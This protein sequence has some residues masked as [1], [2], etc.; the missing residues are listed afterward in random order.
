MPAAR[1][2]VEGVTA[3]YGPTEIVSDISFS[4]SAGERLAVFGRNGVG[5]T[6][7]LAAIMGL[8]TLRRGRIALNGEDL[9]GRRTSFRAQ[10]GLGYVPQTRGVF[11]SLTVEENLAAGLK[12]R[13]RS[14][15][16]EAYEMF[17]RLAER[18]T[19]LAQRLSGGE[20][21]MLALARTLLGEPTI[22]LLDEPLE[23]IAPVVCDEI[24]ERLIA[25]ANSRRIAIV[26]VEQQIERALAF[27]DRAFIIERGRQAWQGTC[28]EL[29]EDRA[30]IQRFLG[31]GVH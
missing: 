10:L 9:S 18:R 19:S 22:L 17:P 16:A 4:V 30:L 13:A 31:V 25:L 1:L 21:Q 26:L 12:R 3:G 2:D 28:G 11:A 5:K 15:L 29:R 6:T 7:L 14:A 24:M 27:A 8:A 23:G 20:Q